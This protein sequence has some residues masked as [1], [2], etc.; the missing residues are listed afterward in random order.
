MISSLKNFSKFTSIRNFVY[1]MYLYVF[2][3]GKLRALRNPGELGSLGGIE[4]KY[5]FVKE[6]LKPYD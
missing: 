2:N 3:R 4:V 6:A 1:Y 5:Y